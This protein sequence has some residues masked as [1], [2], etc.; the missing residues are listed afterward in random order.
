MSYTAI[1]PSPHYQLANAFSRKP[2]IEI[3]LII[4][5]SS[6]PDE[7]SVNQIKVDKP[8]MYVESTPA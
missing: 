6:N 3:I 2:I 4:Q 1:S 8:M 5:W 7:A